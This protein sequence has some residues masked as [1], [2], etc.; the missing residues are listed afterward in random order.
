MLRFLAVYPTSLIIQQVSEK[1]ITSHRKNARPIILQNSFFARFPIVIPSNKHFLCHKITGAW[2]LAQFVRIQYPEKELI[3]DIK[4]NLSQHSSLSQQLNLAPQL[5]QWLKILQTPSLQLQEIVRAELE[6][7]PALEI[8]SDTDAPAVEI[9]E[10]APVKETDFSDDS[11]GEKLEMLASIDEDW[12]SESSSPCTTSR[13]D[14]SEDKHDYLMNSA[15]ST[16]TLCQHLEDQLGLFDL[17]PAQRQLTLTLIGYIDKKGYLKA[18]PADL[19]ADIQAD[20]EQFT[21]AVEIIQQMDPIGVGARSIQEC[22]LI[23][24]ARTQ[25]AALAMEIVRTYLEP[26]ARGLY[27]E[28]ARE[29]NTT[30]DAVIQA[31]SQITALNPVPGSRFEQ[32]ITDYVD[33]DI[34]IRKI[35]N[36]FKIHLLDQRIPRL[37]ISS[38]CRKMMEKGNLSK[39]DIDYIRSRIRSASFLIDG[40]RQREDTLKKVTSQIIHFQKDFLASREGQLKPLTMAK[41]GAIIKVHETTVSRAIANKYIR[42]PRGLMPMRQFFSQGYRC[43]DGSAFTPDAVRDMIQN[44]VRKENKNNPLRDID[45]AQALKTRGLKVARRTI[46]KYREESGIP[47]SKERSTALR[48]KAYPRKTEAEETTAKSS[49]ESLNNVLQLPDMQEATMEAIEQTA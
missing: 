24:L 32:E 1:N 20:S 39:E 4:I 19:S 11:L 31:H 27:G 17:S 14:D 48:K 38:A 7:N 46:A 28:I 9:T 5:L 26:L 41:I 10:E 16:K 30:E 36:E 34:E 6:T 15:R 33:A 18:S 2:H 35:D 25:N 22:L 12:R 21:Q 3:M 47:S 43:A 13:S 8:D 23:Q 37:K 40:I 42:T 49:A 45:I 44:L 29:L